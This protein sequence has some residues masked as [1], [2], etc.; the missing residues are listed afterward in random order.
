MKLIKY[1]GL[2]KRIM[3]CGISKKGAARVIR[4]IRKMD[5]Q[6][7][8]SFGRWYNYNEIPKEPVY[9]VTFDILT[10]SFRMNGFNAFLTLDWIKKEPETAK[11]ALGCGLDELI[12][13]E[14]GYDE[15][16]EDMSDI[17]TEE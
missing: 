2:K 11:A 13:A 3:D 14:T 17:I 7:K 4:E 5:P 6:I 16:G 9:D 1:A 10:G 15:A 12:V 8:R